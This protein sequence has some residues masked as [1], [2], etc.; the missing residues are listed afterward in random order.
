VNR[1]SVAPATRLGYAFLALLAGDLALLAVLLDNAIRVRA[2]L[3]AIHM[4]E[5]ALQIPQALQMF[6]LYAKFSVVG[7]LLVGVPIAL[8]F[9][10]HFV[11]RLRWPVVVLVGGTLGPLALFLIFTLL[12]RGRI[13]FSS[14]GTFTGT[15]WFW[16]FSVLVSTV[17]FSVYAVLLRRATSTEPKLQPQF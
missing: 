9:S 7:W 8:L 5:P 1:H 3:T 4:G 11:A 16:E 12:S 17:A 15:T 13:R 2:S 10:A 14:P 6:K